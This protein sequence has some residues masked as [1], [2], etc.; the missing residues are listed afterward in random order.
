M[1]AVQRLYHYRKSIATKPFNSRG[2]AVKRCQLCLVALENCICQLKP[3]INSDCAFVLLMHEKEVLKPSN[4]GKLIA[5]IIDE[6]YAFIWART[7]VDEQ[8]LTLINDEQ[9]QPYV[10]FPEQYKHQEQRVCHQPNLDTAKKPLFILIDA[11]WRE[12][13]RIFR[14]SP[15]L[16]SLPLLSIH[17]TDFEKLTDRSLYQLR[18]TEQENQ[19]CTAQVASLLLKLAEEDNNANTLSLWLGL[20]N[21]RYLK[22]VNQRNLANPDIEERFATWIESIE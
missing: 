10:V 17:P 22:S 19:L 20:F 6:T 2:K 1:H 18:K 21:Y 3:T 14:K 13:K 9:Y 8:L 4:T 7:E 11:S 16:N 5:D 15:Y 12:A